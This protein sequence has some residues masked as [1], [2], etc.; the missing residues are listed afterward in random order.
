MAPHSGLKP[1]FCRLLAEAKTYF[2]MKKALISYG[3]GLCPG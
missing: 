2:D 1:S 3:Y